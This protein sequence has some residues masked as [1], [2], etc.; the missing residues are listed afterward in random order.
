M[1]E[2][3]RV[4]ANL[5]TFSAK[6]AAAQIGAQRTRILFPTRT[7]HNSG[8]FGFHNVEG[9]FPCVAE[10]PYGGKIIGA[11]TGESGKHRYS[12]ERI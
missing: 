1:P 4:S 2:R 10:S 12:A 7:E 8:N 9:H 6:R 11:L 3:K 5:R